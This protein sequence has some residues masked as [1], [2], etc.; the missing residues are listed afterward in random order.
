MNL[1]TTLRVESLEGQQCR[2]FGNTNY[3]TRLI[4]PIRLGLTMLFFVLIL[5]GG[6]TILLCYM[7]LIEMDQEGQVLDAPAQLLPVVGIAKSFARQI[8]FGA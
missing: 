3:A 1:L 6:G 2:W 7:F 4:K 8:K 5:M